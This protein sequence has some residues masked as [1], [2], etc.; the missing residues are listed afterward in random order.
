[1]SSWE[2]TLRELRGEFVRG[3]LQRVE[4]MRGMLRALDASPA[5]AALRHELR[6]Q[7]HGLAGSG[8]TYG[9]PEVTRLGLTGERLLIDADEARALEASSLRSL[10]GLVD[11]LRRALEP[12]DAASEPAPDA[13]AA[14]AAPARSLVLVVED[15]A[16]GSAWLR[17]RLERQGYDVRTAGSRAEALA[18]VA[19]RAPDAVICGV[20]LP[21]GRGYELVA[22]LRQLAQAEDV[23]VL[24]ASGQADFLDKVEAITSGADGC[25]ATPV[26]WDELLLR[27]QH[28]LE[29]RL[30]QPSRILCVEDFEEQAVYL[31]SVLASVGYE[32]ELLGDPRGFEAALVGF[33]PDLVLMD[34][35]LPGVSG[36]ELT[37][38]L[39]QDPRFASLPVLMMTT[40]AQPDAR[41]RGLKAGADDHLVKP[42]AP[43]L[44]LTAVASHLERARLVRSLSE[45]DGLTRLL[46][47]SAFLLRAREA[48]LRF[49]G[50]AQPRAAL[51]MLDLDQLR[52][53]NERFGY[54]AGDAVLASFAGLLRRR[55]R[56]SDALGRY[57]GEEFGALLLGLEPDEVARLVQRLR[58]EFAELEQRAPDGSGFRVTVSSGV[59]P[60][61]RGCAS[62]EAWLREA[63]AALGEA[64]RRATREVANG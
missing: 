20:T 38:F 7:F 56:E 42:I 48:F 1:M 62:L 25:F 60:L 35:L 30:L 58:D 19:E 50:V 36:Y 21:D 13:P 23:P 61:R 8:S 27:L 51:V 26:D 4:K 55:L 43:A 32:V 53:V 49:R 14:A 9:L 64:K 16:A 28:L 31:K 52:A 24:M 22:A 18:A 11:E 37:R 40:D 54:A 59:A 2:E 46:T 10:A 3:S 17:E 39:R 15:D 41:I 57:A 6:V 29:R 45:R 5:D 12:S 63:D 34:I 47:H 44:L 33:R